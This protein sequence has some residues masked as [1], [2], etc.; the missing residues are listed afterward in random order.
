[1]EA[2]LG[3]LVGTD[4]SK[5]ISKSNVFGVEHQLRKYGSPLKSAVILKFIYPFGAII[6]GKELYGTNC[7]PFKNK[8]DK[9]GH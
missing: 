4:I 6:I 3:E 1:M 2:G 5:I 8:D 7:N 9:H